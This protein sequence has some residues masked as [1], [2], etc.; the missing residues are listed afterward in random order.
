MAKIYQLPTPLAGTVDVLPVQKYMVVGDNL[1]TVTTT[2]Y[3]NQINLEGY[4][5]ANT[6]IINMLYSYNP[7]TTVGTFE[8]FSV[9][10]SNGVITLN[11]LSSAGEVTLPTIANHIATYT[12]TTGHLS[13]DPA[14][15]ISGGN[16]QAGLSG[17]AGYLASFPSTASTGSLRLTAVSNSGNTVTTI[18]N[19]AMGQASTVNIPDPANA[20][21]QFLVGSTATPFVDGNFPKNSGTAGLMVDSGIAVSALAT[22]STAVLLAPSG[23]QTI[24]AH[25]LT[26]SQGNLQAGSSGH[27]GTLTS[28]PGTA[29]KGSLKLVA[30]NN[31]DDTITTISNAAMGQATVVSIPDPA[32]ATADF[33][34]APAALV[35]GNAVKASGTAGL[36]VDAGYAFHA[37]TTGTYAGGG[38]SNAFTVTGMAATWIVTAS[39]L[40]QTNA[41]SIVKAVPG[42]NTLTIT[43][44]ADPG[45]NT[46]VS[47][48]ASTAAV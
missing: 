31:T 39:I 9:S 42:T 34:L 1:S 41:A 8:Q 17:T 25:N 22:T 30:V 12:N 27:A 37:G 10:I 13:E 3:L 2:G 36:V 4:S 11:P 23:D 20:V 35:S 28:F 7:V 15:A 19:D 45:A 33:V 43:F 6:D 46:T 14:T 40:T 5:L 44:S 16:I 32:T 18:S 38:T 21:G 29:S 48:V 26:V 24:T 47:W